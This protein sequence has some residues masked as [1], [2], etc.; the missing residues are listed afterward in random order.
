VSFFV[1]LAAIEKGKLVHIG[2]EPSGS[3]SEGKAKV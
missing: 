3:L 2:T 1:Y